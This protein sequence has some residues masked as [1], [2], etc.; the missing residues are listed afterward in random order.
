MS[1]LPKNV[2]TLQVK[3]VFWYSLCSMQSSTHTH[4]HTPSS[5]SNLV[6]CHKIKPQKHFKRGLS[7]QSPLLL[8]H[9]SLPVFTAAALAASTAQSLR[10]RILFL[11]CVCA[12]RGTGMFT[13]EGQGWWIRRCIC[14]RCNRQMQHAS[15]LLMPFT[16]RSERV[17]GFLVQEK[18]VLYLTFLLRPI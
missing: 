3:C 14:W 12:R 6:C 17:K 9:H 5:T 7:S 16:M 8:W 13:S 4:T 1:S 10:C 2:F 15:V 11:L 18:S